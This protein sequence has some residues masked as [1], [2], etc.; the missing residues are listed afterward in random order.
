MKKIVFVAAMSLAGLA[1]AAQ[2][3]G[4]DSPFCQGNGRG[5]FGF[6][7]SP[8]PA[9]QAAPWYLYWPY[10]QHFMTPAPIGGAYSAPPM[11][12]GGLVNPYFP[13][14]QFPSGGMNY[15]P[16]ASSGA[17]PMTTGGGFA[18][19]QT[20]PAPMPQPGGVVPGVTPAPGATPPVTPA[21]KNVSIPVPGVLRVSARR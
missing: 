21:P 11:G 13:G 17:I 2:A 15:A 9:F 12:Y 18:P 20:P 14:G 7:R 16:P 3:G 19:S 1:S 8:M 5:M 6:G 4:C 10:N